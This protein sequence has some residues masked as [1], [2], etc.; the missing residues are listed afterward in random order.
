MPEGAKIRDTVWVNKWKEAGIRCRLC[1]RDYV[2][3]EKNKENI[4][5]PTP[6][7]MTVRCILFCGIVY[8]LDIVIGDLTTAFM[9]ATA[10]EEMYCH[11]PIEYR[12]PGWLWK[13]EKAINGMRGASADVSDFFAAVAT[14]KLHLKR[15]VSAPCVFR[16]DKEKL[17]VGIHVDDPLAAGEHYILKKSM[18]R[19][20]RSY[21]AS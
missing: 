4:F 17:I 14:Q 15:L 19:L 18:G 1:L 13:I 12:V 9:H 20:T 5:S 16:A 11:T 3:L 7:P 8:D 6:T 10:S 21:D 2:S